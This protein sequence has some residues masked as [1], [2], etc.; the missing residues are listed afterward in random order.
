VKLD[1]CLA[2]AYHFAPFDRY[3]GA[4]AMTTTLP[5]T[6]AAVPDIALAAVVVAPNGV[7]GPLRTLIDRVSNA[8]VKVEVVDEIVEAAHHVK[9][10]DQYTALLLDC[11]TLATDDP[12]DLQ[13]A[14]EMIKKCRTAMPEHYPIIVASGAS[15]SFIVAAFRAGAGDFIDMALEGTTHARSVIARACANMNIKAADSSTV[16]GLRG[17]VEEFLREL[18]RTE[19]AKI[20]LEERLLNPHQDNTK[21]TPVILLV[22]DDKT[23]AD[24]L[25]VT[26]ESKGLT[27]YAFVNGED[28]VAAVTSNRDNVYFDLALV[29]LGLPGM[30]GLATIE[31]L[32]QIIP[33]LAGFLMANERE[34]ER[35]RSASERSIV[36]YIMK[37]FENFDALTNKLG[38]LAKDAMLKAQEQ[39]YL[40]QIKARHAGLLERFRQI[41]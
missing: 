2:G 37:P 38:S 22:E 5:R 24:R 25:T 13:M 18:I 27:T 16:K 21:R 7:A 29:D 4:A 9:N 6:T 11:R 33:G 39:R 14:T 10:S 41:G 34:R 23:I 26:F 28:A 3:C 31:Q 20:N 1:F 8:G 40:Q 35:V 30:D 17:I 32:R 15:N 12:Q 36:G 19:R